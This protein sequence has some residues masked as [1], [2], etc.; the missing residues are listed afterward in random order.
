MLK[1]ILSAILFGNVICQDTTK[2]VQGP[3]GPPGKRGDM[4]QVGYPG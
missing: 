3:P 1:V 2:G 4:G